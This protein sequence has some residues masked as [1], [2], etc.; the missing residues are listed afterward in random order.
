MA[1]PFKQGRVPWWN[2]P[3]FKPESIVRLDQKCLGLRVRLA[4]GERITMPLGPATFNM[5]FPR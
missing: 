4:S 3:G 2:A 5:R 1:E